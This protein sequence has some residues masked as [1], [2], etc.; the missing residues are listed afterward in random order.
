MPRI[1]TIFGLRIPRSCHS[2][3]SRPSLPGAASSSS[4]SSTSFFTQPLSAVPI[5]SVL[6]RTLGTMAEV[7]LTSLYEGDAKPYLGA[8]PNCL[9]ESRNSESIC[10]LLKQEAPLVSPGLRPCSTPLMRVS[11]LCGV[12]TAE[13]FE[14]LILLDIC[15]TSCCE[16]RNATSVPTTLNGRNA[17]PPSHNRPLSCFIR[18]VE[19][20]AR[21]QA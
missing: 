8:W 14:P 3:D 17:Y 1:Y 10:L 5:T 9:P 6:T 2:R 16:C 18:H 15:D 12:Q 7:A 11:S 13:M 20:N 21:S 19:L 4:K